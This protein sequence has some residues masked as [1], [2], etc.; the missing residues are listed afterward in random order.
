MQLDISFAARNVSQDADD[1]YARLIDV[2][3]GD[4]LRFL[5]TIENVG[6]SVADNVTVRV[7]P[8]PGLQ[9][10]SRSV[11]RLDA[12][13]DNVQS[14]LALFDGGINF[15]SYARPGGFYVYYDVVV[16]DVGTVTDCGSRLRAQVFVWADRLPETTRTTDVLVGCGV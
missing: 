15:G 2:Q 4:T 7:V 8:P 6:S 11:R 14:D 1:Q 16:V 3:E 10:V 13:Q 9:L 12:S 5:I